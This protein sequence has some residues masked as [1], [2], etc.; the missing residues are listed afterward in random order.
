MH[1]KDSLWNDSDPEYAPLSKKDH[2][3]WRWIPAKK[4]R[5]AGCAIRTCRLD[6]PH[7]ET[8]S[9]EQAA[10][11]R[12][13]TRDLLRWYEGVRKG[14]EHGTW[15]WLIGRY[16]SDEFSAIND[17][18]PSTRKKYREWMRRIEDAIGNVEISNTDCARMVGWKRSMQD[19][20]RSVDYINR[21][22]T[23]FMIVVSHGI[24]ISNS[25]IRK[26][27][28]RIKEVR[29]EMRIQSAPP[30]SQ[31][32]TWEQ[33]NRIVEDADK[34][35][36]HQLSLAVLLRFE[37]MLRGVDV[38][39]EWEPAERGSGGILWSCRGNTRR[40]VK[41]LTWE[42]ISPDVSF[43][44][45]VISKTARSLPEP[46]TFELTSVPDIRRRL[47]LTPEDQR[48]GPVIKMD[49]GLPPRSSQLSKQFKVIVRSRED[50]SSD[51]RMS[52]ARSGGITEASNLVD[53]M[54]LRNAAQHKQVTTTDRY[55]RARS[56]SANN[57]V[58]MRL[59][60][61]K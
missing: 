57:V 12:A 25:G 55:V 1:F 4:Y 58:K 42:M 43:F 18:Q 36:W 35:G 59:D 11:C 39:G 45:K 24:K 3:V 15:G 48:V 40:W 37:F 46:Y 52:D 51:L 60:A 32:I 8:P 9:L 17:V 31:T 28:L 61:R 53:P 2:G 47:M 20:G 49:D 22:F 7:G 23:H 6:G 29:S 13:L 41:G 10:Q 34:R 54:T 56:Q 33:V 26:E 38:Y 27:C 19:K 30:R 5:D 21:W 16:K 44:E 14:R 50:L